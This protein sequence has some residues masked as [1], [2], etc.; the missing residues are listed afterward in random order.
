[1][2]GSIP[3]IS[4]PSQWNVEKMKKDFPLFHRGSGFF[5]VFFFFKSYQKWGNGKVNFFLLS[6][7][8]VVSAGWQC[9]GAAYFPQIYLRKRTNASVQKPRLWSSGC[10]PPILFPPWSLFLTSHNNVFNL[11]FL[12]FCLIWSMCCQHY[13]TWYCSLVIGRLL[14]PFPWSACQ[15]VLGRDT[16]PQN[17]MIGQKSN[18]FSYLKTEEV[19]HQW[20]QKQH[21]TLSTEQHDCCMDQQQVY[22]IFVIRCSLVR[23]RETLSFGL[24]Y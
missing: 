22:W 11:L 6:Q 20:T 1:M 3:W 21:L 4:S 19:D 18:T 9:W 24:K 15:S 8:T 10:L 5:V 23:S 16:E 13:F 14:V 12:T 7:T 17:A 2:P